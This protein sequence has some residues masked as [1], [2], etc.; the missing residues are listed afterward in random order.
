MATEFIKL[1]NTF[2]YV[3][4]KEDKNSTSTSRYKT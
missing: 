2:L 4:N 3:T 1:D